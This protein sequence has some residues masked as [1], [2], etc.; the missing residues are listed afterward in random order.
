[1]L[2]S[3]SVVSYTLVRDETIEITTFKDFEDL[4]LKVFFLCIFELLPHVYPNQIIL[5][6]IIL[7][8]EFFQFLNRL[9][10]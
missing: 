9:F 10:L 1:M 6:A 2:F 8:G 5:L 3:L 4:S 7:R